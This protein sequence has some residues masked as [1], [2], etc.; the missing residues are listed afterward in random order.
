M[1]ADYI[2]GRI[3]LFIFVSI[4]AYEDF[5]YKSID[6][7]VYVFMYICEFLFYMYLIA[8]SKK[9]ALMDIGLGALIGMLL[10]AASKLGLNIGEG[11]AHFFIIT[12]IGLGFTANAKILLCTLILISIVAL[13]IITVDFINRVNSK[14]KVLPMLVFALPV[15]G[16][17]LFS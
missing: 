14:N 17:I 1:I 10:F 4:C 11:D 7:R 12:G 13:Y 3:L 6:V 5:K 15:V 16:Y 2:V 9:L 8:L